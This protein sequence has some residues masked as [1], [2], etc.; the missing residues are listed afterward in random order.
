MSSNWFT[1]LA[2]SNTRNQLG[3]YGTKG[4]E[5]SSNSP[6]ARGSFTLVFHPRTNSIYIYGGTGYDNASQGPR[7]TCH[8]QTDRLY[9]FLG[10]LGDLW[11]YNIT[12]GMWTWLT[13]ASTVNQHAVFNTI[14][15]ESPSTTPGGA[16]NF[17]M[18]IAPEND[19]IYQFGS[20]RVIAGSYS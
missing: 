1:W 18:T 20:T 16:F 19:L 13:G 4:V 8:S 14:N 7:L 10:P 5:A 15:V 6:G 2:G 11:R 3:T 17:G 9:Y 12:S